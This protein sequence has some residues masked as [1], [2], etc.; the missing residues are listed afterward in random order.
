MRKVVVTKKLRRGSDA[1]KNFH[2]F[3]RP[4][5]KSL[6]ADP[7]LQSITLLSIQKVLTK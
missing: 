1:S 2:D 6:E 5:D 4:K 7:N 3:E